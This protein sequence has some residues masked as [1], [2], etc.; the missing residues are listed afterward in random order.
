[1]CG[2]LLHGMYVGGIW[3]AVRHGVSAGV[4]GLITALQPILT[5]ALAPWIVG[6]RLRFIQVLGI[7]T[8]FIGIGLVLG[9]TVVGNQ[10]IS[11]A[12]KI[13]PLASN[14]LGAIGVTLGYIYQKR[15]IPTGDLRT[16]TVLQYCGA[17]LAILPAALLL[18]DFQ[19][20]WN[21]TV[22]LSLAWSV[23][24]LSIGAIALLLVLLR[25]GAVARAAGLSYLVP[26]FTAIEAYFMFGEQLTW[27]QILGM[28][29]TAAG[30]AMIM[31]RSI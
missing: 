24:M 27:V 9:P 19:V 8:G 2:A 16:V 28:C 10:S 20:T 30:V 4:A 31:R 26:V 1:M 5:A 29:V 21:A 17:F 12:D 6:E 15:F 25:N 18:E 11:F 7:A 14:V 23:L 13:I 22:L 3:W